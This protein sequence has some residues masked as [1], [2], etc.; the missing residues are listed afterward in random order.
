MTDQDFCR[1][2]LETGA[3]ENILPHEG[4]ARYQAPKFF[5]DGSG[6][7]LIADQER[8]YLSV[9]VKPHGVATLTELAAFEGRDVEALAISPDQNAI[10]LV[11]NRQGWNDVVLIGRDGV[12][13]KQLEMPVA[14]V[15]ASMAWAPDGTSLIMPVEGATMSGDIWR[16]DVESGVFT[17]LTDVPKAKVKLPAFVEPTVT[18]VASFDGL[19]IPLFRLQAGTCSRP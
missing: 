4:R 8:E 10:A 2:D 13:R 17:R 11:V 7:L 12:V 6:I 19:E 15:V 9:M 18:S 1:L 16:C 14:A 5:K 3:Y